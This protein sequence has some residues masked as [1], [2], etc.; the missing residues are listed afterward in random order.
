MQ[1]P[2]VRHTLDRRNM[3]ETQITPLIVSKL[4]LH[5]I[6]IFIAL[7]ETPCVCETF[8]WASCCPSLLVY[9]LVNKLM[10]ST[11]ISHI[12]PLSPVVAKG[13]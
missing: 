10:T 5:H 9:W 2:V 8:F 13:H 4:E 12:S 11:L 1:V 3:S 7:M 6:N